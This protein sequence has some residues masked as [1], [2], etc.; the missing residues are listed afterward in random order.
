M[1][2]V[3][4]RRT[5]RSDDALPAMKLRE[6]IRKDGRAIF[7]GH[8]PHRATLRHPRIRRPIHRRTTADVPLGFLDD[9]QPELGHI[10]PPVTCWAKVK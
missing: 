4:R 9:E 6:L 8:R 5:Q 7:R 3:A 10:S 2:S 1:T